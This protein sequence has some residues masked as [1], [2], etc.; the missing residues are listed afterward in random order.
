MFSE[1]KQKLN[2]G[3]ALAYYD[4][5]FG[6]CDIDSELPGRLG[7][8]KIG[9]VDEDIQVVDVSGG[10]KANSTDAIA[11]GPAGAALIGEASRGVKSILIKDYSLDNS[12]VA[13]IAENNTILVMPVSDLMKVS[14]IKRS[15]LMFKMQRLVESA[16]KHKIQVAFV[17]M[18]DSRGNMCS[19][20]QLIELSKLIGADGD[21]ARRSVSETNRVLVND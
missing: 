4:L 14:G 9:I 21:Y 16:K 10:K 7:F 11:V 1:W 8:K 17:T 5:V 15:R 19:Y 18:A 3:V 2:R 6:S 20:M 13:A 12:L